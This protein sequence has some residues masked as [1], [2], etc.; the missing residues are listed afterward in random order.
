[1]A[2]TLHSDGRLI[3]VEILRSGGNLQLDRL[4]LRTLT[5]SSPFPPPPPTVRD[6]PL[7]F[8]IRFGFR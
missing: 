3:A 2:F 5:G 4:A 6:R 1:M 7:R 8:T